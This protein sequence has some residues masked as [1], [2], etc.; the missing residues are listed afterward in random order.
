M[1]DCTLRDGG[2]Y[3]SWDFEK[4]LV[5]EYLSVMSKIENDVVEIGFKSFKNNNFKG[6]Y[7]FSNEEF[8]K[9][10]RLPS[11]LKLSVMINAS[12]FPD[13]DDEIKEK[14]NILFQ[15]ILIKQN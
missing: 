6:P 12:E 10:L 5:E 1:L 7:A 11:N 15:V 14:I 9:S 3:N 2:Y 8:I 13:D 4:E